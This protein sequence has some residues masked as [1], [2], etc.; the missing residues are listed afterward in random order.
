MT[1]FSNLNN[2]SI[3]Q[4]LIGFWIVIVFTVLD[5]VPFNGFAHDFDGHVEYT[6]ILLNEKRLPKPD[7]GWETRQ[8]PLYYLISSH[9]APDKIMSDLPVHVYYVRIFSALCGAATIA[10][11]AWFL[12]EFTNNRF[13]QVLSILFVASTPKFV[14]I[15]T[16]YNNDSL[17]TALSVAMI[18][19]SY[20]LCK[21][22]NKKL[23]W[24][25]FIVSLAGLYTKLTFLVPMFIII[26]LCLKELVLKKKEYMKENQKKIILTLSFSL[27]FLLP[28]I[29]FHNY[30]TVGQLL[31][32]N[33][34]P[35]GLKFEKPL[36]EVFSPLAI[37]ENKPHK[38]DVPWVFM[39]PDAS[40][41]RNDYLSYVFITSVIGEFFFK[42]Q[43]I[44]LVWALFFIHLV[45]YLFALRYV[46]YSKVTKLAGIFILMTHLLHIVWIST[47]P[48]SVSMDYRF[49]SWSSI[50]WMILYA[51][52]LHASIKKSSNI[53]SKLMIAGIILNI[54]FMNTVV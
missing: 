49:I 23:G 44:N 32:S 46:L 17:A 13:I 33:S 14:F 5:Q 48:F 2:K 39:W 52:A 9:I 3:I 40:S 4:L 53:L 28:W 26:A 50:G 1:D 25:L 10:L 42:P 6:K 19:L 51:S 35:E 37:L 31:P 18:V 8:Q 15:F 54:I 30:S 22:W 36:I 47:Q 34:P 7:E 27:L 29:F 20:K 45:V 24:A 12:Q 38:W 21:D 16:T 11:F 41:K 43:C